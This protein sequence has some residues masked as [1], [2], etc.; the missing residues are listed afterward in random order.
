MLFQSY[1]LFSFADTSRTIGQNSQKYSKTSSF[2]YCEKNPAYWAK[3]SKLFHFSCRTWSF[4]FF[5]KILS[6]CEA[7]R[8]GAALRGASLY[9][10]SAYLA[11]TYTENGVQTNVEEGIP[12]HSLDLTYCK[13][14][15][16]TT[17]PRKYGHY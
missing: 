12:Q 9:P 13:V 3:N 6:H 4:W 10:S 17:W 8:P 16:S 7:R 1:Y 11:A 2:Y 14:L 5:W 15:L